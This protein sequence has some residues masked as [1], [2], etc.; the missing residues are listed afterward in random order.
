MLEFVEI[1]HQ[2]IIINKNEWFGADHEEKERVYDQHEEE[3]E[4]SMPK[5]EKKE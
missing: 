1:P 5:K 4:T 2:I 3:A